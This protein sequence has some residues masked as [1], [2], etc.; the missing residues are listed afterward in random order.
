M[1]EYFYLDD[2]FV[3]QYDSAYPDRVHVSFRHEVACGEES[4]KWGYFKVRTG[5][6]DPEFTNPVDK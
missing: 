4:S 1:H 3:A 6:A 5:I 2:V